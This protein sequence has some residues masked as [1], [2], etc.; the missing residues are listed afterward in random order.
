MIVTNAAGHA[1]DADIIIGDNGRILR[2]VGINKT[3]RTGDGNGSDVWSTGGFLSFNY[4]IYGTTADGYGS[5]GNAA[6]YD[7]I[8]ARGVEFLDYHEG[9][10]DVTAAARPR[11]SRRA[12][13]RV[14]R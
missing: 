8:V 11:K 4:D 1:Q 10:I 3:Q 14:G 5:D 6:T 9:G 2:L 13:R 12:P 7:R